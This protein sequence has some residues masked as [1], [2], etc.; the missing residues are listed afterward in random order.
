MRKPSP[1]LMNTSLRTAPPVRTPVIPALG[2]AHRFRL[3]NGLPVVAIG[4]AE[5]PILRVEFLCQGG[6][7]YEN[8]RLVA[9]AATD[10]V[11]EGT[12]KRTA[13]QLEHFFEQYGTSLETPNVTD[14]GNLSVSTLNKHA[15]T[16]LPVMAEVIAE[17]AFAQTAFRR[18][19]RQRRQ[20]LRENLTDNDTLAYRLI[21]EATY[22]SDH[23]YGYNGFFPDYDRLRLDDIKAFYHGHFHAANGTLLVIGQIDASTER[24]LDATFG[25]LPP[26]PAV[27]P[28]VLP[29]TPSGAACLQLLR[30]RAQQTMI[31]RGRAGIHIK[32]PDYPALVVL[33]TVLGGYFGS[34]LMR[35]IRE[36]KGFTY[37]IDSEL[38]TYRFDGSM[39]IS[40][41][42]ANDN[43]QEVRQEILV[44]IDKLRQTPVP[45]AELDM[46]RA[47]LGGSIAMELD[48]P[49]GHGWRYRSAIIKDYEPVS[50]LR[51][52]HETIR[53]I[54]PQELLTV[55]QKHLRPEEDKEVIVGGADRL[56]EATPVT[57]PTL[58]LNR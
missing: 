6:R 13:S 35:N 41:D 8:Q 34:R 32:D 31:R 28:P 30:P 11:V 3:S 27:A 29:P 50:F 52:L 7:P 24:L 48:G 54:S 21:T 26:G 14:T 51:R 17:P 12:R 18:F 53:D 4:G 57:D 36:E 25:Q 22:G 15:E 44:E 23:P 39:E 19:M 38:D 40:A 10:L 49:F 9:G 20:Q 55:A 1:K 45:A 16:V 56:P 5:A 2:P 42:V 43:L 33:D 46:V 58:P 47:Y 37:G